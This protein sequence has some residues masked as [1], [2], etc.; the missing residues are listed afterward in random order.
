MNYMRFLLANFSFR[1]SLDGST[2][3]RYISHSSQFCVIST[4]AEVTLCYIIQIINE[5]VKQD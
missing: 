4:F 3:F 2:T 5:D 1:V